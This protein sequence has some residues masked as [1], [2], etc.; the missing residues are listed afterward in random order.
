MVNLRKA[1]TT[2]P[3]AQSSKS[4]VQSSLPEYNIPCGA[5]PNMIQYFVAVERSCLN[6]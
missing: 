2:L 1:N 6:L 4:S 3:S 5:A